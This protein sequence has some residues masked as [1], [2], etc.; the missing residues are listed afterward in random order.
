MRCIEMTAPYQMQI[1][2]K[3]VP[4]PKEG[5]ALLRVLY[6]GICGSDLGLY[7]GSMDGYA[8]YPRV[9]GHEIA[10]EIV[11]IGENPAGLKA[12]TLVTMNPYF[13][14]GKCYSCSRGYVNCCTNNQ[15]MGLGCEGGFAEYITMPTD[16]LYPGN[17]LDA[18]RLALIE[19]FCISYHALKRGRVKPQERVLIVGAG[20]IGM[21]AL[22]NAKQM[23]AKVYV[24]NVTEKKLELAQRL[25]ADGVIYNDDDATFRSKVDALTDGNGFDVVVEAAGQSSTMLNCLDAV[26][27]RGRVVEVGINNRPTEV[28]FSMVEKKEMEILGSRNAMREDFLEL[29]DLARYGKLNVEA[30]V[31]GECGLDEA[32]AMFEKLDKHTGFNL[33]TL[34]RFQ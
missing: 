6:G 20:T 30:I 27:H 22:L 12:G 26:A 24:A 8:T 17:G 25:G 23:G 34:I 13:N 21:G 7:R 29:I 9:P 3:A 11:E 31:T 4:V 32:P 33:K 16:R 18:R 15:T 28:L 1:V 19:P 5:E 2:E 14:C 10:A